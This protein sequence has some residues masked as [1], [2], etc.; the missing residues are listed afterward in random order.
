[1]KPGR[2]DAGMASAGGTTSS[3]GQEVR[4][5]LLLPLLLERFEPEQTLTV[6]DVGYGVPETVEFFSQYA[7]RLHFAGLID[8]PEL[9]AP[10]PEED[11]GGYLDATFERLCD[12]PAD[13]RFDICLLW[14]FLNY[15]PAPA[16]YSFSRALTPYLH[17]DSRAHGFGAFK[18]AA[19]MSR[20]SRTA[21]Q[22]GVYASDELL[23][24]PRP[25]ARPPGHSHS[26]AVLAHSLSCF[27]IVRGTLLREGHMELLLQA[28]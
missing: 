13:T 1:M 16:L 11:P 23:V 21:L 19:S 5:T 27:E 10:V 18:A 17:R 2:D 9:S 3:S 12:F 7:C 26:R 8:A 20:D 28:R 24:R 22:Y 14:D 6:L 25:G 15:L 4:S